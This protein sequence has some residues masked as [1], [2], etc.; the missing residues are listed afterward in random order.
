[1]SSL[2]AAQAKDY[3]FFAFH[4]APGA[5]THYVLYLDLD[6]VE[7]SGASSDAENYSVTTIPAHQPEY[8]VYVVPYDAAFSANSAILRRWNGATSCLGDPADA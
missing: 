5:N 2:Y 7:G 1:M 8:A 3:W 6:H 4:A